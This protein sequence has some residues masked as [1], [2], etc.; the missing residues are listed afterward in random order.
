MEY[1]FYNYLFGTCFVKPANNTPTIRCHME[2]DVFPFVSGSSLGFF[3]M[4]SQ[5]DIP[6]HCC[7]G[8][9]IKD[10]NQHPR[11]L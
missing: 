6:C 7:P 8:L 11:F 10:I 1:I 5:G 9:L 2:E 3:P 4:S